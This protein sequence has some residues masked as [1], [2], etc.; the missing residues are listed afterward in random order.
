MFRGKGEMKQQFFLVLVSSVALLVMAGLEVPQNAQ[1]HDE[2]VILQDNLGNHHYL[3]S[4]TVSRA[5]QYFDQGLILSFGFNHAEAGRSFLEAAR[6]DP[7]CAMCY[8]GAALVLGPNINAP[9]DSGAVPIAFQTL[10]QAQALAGQ[11]TKK[12]QALIQALTHRYSEKVVTD[13][14]S[15]DEA[16]VEAMRKVAQQFPDDPVIGSL[17]AEALM[18]L[19]PWDFWTKEGQARPWTAEIVGRLERVLDFAPNHPLANHL[20]IHAIEASPHPEKAVPSAERL[21]T[22]VPGSG[23]LVHMP[24]HVY[25]RVGRYSD[26]AR[27]NKHAVGIDH[28]YLSQA[29]AES[30][31]TL[32]Y[33]PHNHHFLWAAA[34]KTGQQALALKAAHDT[35]NLVKPAMLRAPGLGA[36]FQHFWIMPLYTKTLFGQWKEIL[37]E[38]APPVDLLYPTG[39]WHYARGLALVRQGK[40][41]QAQQEQRQ[42]QEVIKNPA[43]APMKIFGINAIL[44]ILK[45]GEAV[46]ASEI[47]EGQ[48]EYA[49]AVKHLDR[50]IDIEDGLNYT[51]PKDWYLPPRQILGAVLLNAGKAQ[52]AE[53]VYREDLAYHPKNGWTLY[54]LAQSLRAQGK[55]EAADIVQK[56]FVEAWVES[57]VTLTSSRF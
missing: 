52:E 26:A 57:D 48:G 5:Q 37:L 40:L 2:T 55:M 49:R 20:Y 3:I 1:A 36:T 46:L 9:M 32:A 7:N 50:A 13:R 8:W 44:E 21:E 11:T 54:G 56:Q 19:H 17:L 6:L 34:T 38:P 23:H 51:E 15:L 41:E 35:A 33:V 30:I 47:A 12:E 24:G 29:H 53:A 22:L 27:V 28:H 42:L 31:Y 39:V 25:I 14:R 45:I 16:Y 18:D 4:T 10:Q 43:I